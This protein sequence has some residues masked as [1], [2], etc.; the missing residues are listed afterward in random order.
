MAELS[1]ARRVLA[2]VRP[3]IV[4]HLAGSVGASPDL[5]LVSPTYQSLLTSTINVL[6]GATEVGCRRIVLTGSLTEPSLAKPS[7][8]PSPH[9]PQPKWDAGGYGRMFH[10]LYR[11]PGSQFCARSWPMA[12]RRRE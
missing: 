1:T 2:A 7:P 8:L 12:Q 4:F 10:S 6:I 3:N 5:E 11:T 9:M